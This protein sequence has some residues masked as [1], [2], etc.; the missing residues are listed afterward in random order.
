MTVKINDGGPAFPSQW[1]DKDCDGMT[2]RAYI[3]AHAMQGVLASFAGFDCGTPPPDVVADDAVA[4]ADAL[5]AAL[6]NTC[7]AQG[8]AA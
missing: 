8:E 5:I 4:Y 3:A 7:E 6:T 1:D 2:L